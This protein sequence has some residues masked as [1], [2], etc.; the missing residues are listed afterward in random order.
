MQKHEWN[1]ETEDGRRYNRAYYH[2]NRWSFSTTLQTDPDWQENVKLDKEILQGFREILW[3]KY[4][5]RRATW[6][7]VHSLDKYLEAEHGI[8]PP[9]RP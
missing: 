7:V 6:K 8:E 9:V 1:I 3:A 2:A 5:R 4:Q